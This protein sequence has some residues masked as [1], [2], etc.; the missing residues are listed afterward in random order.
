MKNKI[1]ADVKSPL[2]DLE[3]SNIATGGKQL[4]SVQPE[5]L[6][7]E[8]DKYCLYWFH[9]KE[10]TDFL[11]EGYIGITKDF[12]KRLKDH[13]KNKKF[14]EIW[15]IIIKDIIIENIS[16]EKALYLENKYRPH[17]N[18]GWNSQKGGELGVES[19]W[20]LIPENKLKHSKATSEATKKAIALKDTKEK[21]SLRAKNARLLSDKFNNNLGSNNPRAKLNENQVLDIKQNYLNSNLT[22]K[23]IA[24][25]FDVTPYIIWSIKSGRSWNHITCDSPD[26]NE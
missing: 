4:N 15:N 19:E 6:S 18:I 21:R 2:I 12:N 22:Q 23:E 1:N 17:Q 13:K 24:K 20:Y 10:H 5:R 11:N 8:S 25:I 3:A 14:K 9:L 7:E 26:H 16:L